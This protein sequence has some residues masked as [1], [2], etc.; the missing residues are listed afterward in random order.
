MSNVAISIIIP[1]YNC[2]EYIEQ[3]LE[4]TLKQTLKEIEIICIDDGSLDKSY[5]ILQEY[6]RQYE[7]IHIYSQINS[8][9]GSARNLGLN[10]AKGQ[11][12]AFLDA[13]DFYLDFDALEKMYNVCK[14]K[15][16]SVC[17]SFGKILEGNRLREANFYNTSNLSTTDIHKYD[18][19]QMDC[20][21]YTF[22]YERKVLLEYNIKFPLYRRFQDPPFMVRAM[23]HAERFAMADTRLYCY[24]APNLIQRFNQ[25]KLIDMLNGVNDN[26]CFSFE[27]KMNKLFTET[28]HRLEYDYVYIILHNISS[29]NLQKNNEVFFILQSINR[30]VQDYY[31]D[32]TYLLRVLQMMMS[33][34]A[35]Y[36][37]QYEELLN[38]KIQSLN[39][40]VIYGAGRYAKNFLRYLEE[41]QMLDKV[42]YIVVSSRNSNDEKLFG[43]DVIDMDIFMEN[44]T[45][46]YV[47]VAVGAMNHEEIEEILRKNQCYDFELMDDAFLGRIG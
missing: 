41:R 40:I 28:L 31:G 34:A 14:E 33:K 35:S 15:K 16:V 26:L 5:E 3:C 38:K 43:I 24:R 19:F 37:T 27:H 29:D 13:D 18:D 20:G 46:E 32:E 12:V 39:H 6:A 21:Y 17:G 45:D 23:Y 7:C 10:H 47:F 44:R 11:Y 22:I 25:D 2:E 4:S 36:C 1:V 8:G 42:T 30:L 9:A